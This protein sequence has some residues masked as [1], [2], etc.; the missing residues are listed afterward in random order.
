MSSI[1]LQWFTR[2]MSHTGQQ[3]ILAAAR[4][5][6]AD[7]IKRDNKS[8]FLIKLAIASCSANGSQFLSLK[9]SIDSIFPLPSLPFRTGIVQRSAL[10]R[11][12]VG[13][14]VPNTSSRRARWLCG[15]VSHA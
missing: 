3:S 5:W 12:L 15:R 14:L 6:P 8:Q 2:S 13:T 9:R 4:L 1:D 7:L 10:C 11:K